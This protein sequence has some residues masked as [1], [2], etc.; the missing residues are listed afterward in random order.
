MHVPAS[1]QR[2]EQ[3]VL[4]T[5]SI[6]GLRAQILATQACDA[7]IISRFVD[8]SGKRMLDLVSFRNCLR[9][10]HFLRA[11]DYAEEEIYS[12]L[13]HASVYMMDASA[14]FGAR[15]TPIEWSNVMVALV[16][17]AHSYVLDETCPLSK[18]HRYLCRDYCSLHV[19]DAAV[20][21]LMATR[22]YVLRVDSKILE[23]RYAVF[24]RTAV[25]A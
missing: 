18:W 17:I 19:L 12:V 2:D 1:H 14:K 25:G 6:T 22:R 9:V 11:C 24:C 15:M 13:V 5:A 23:Y 10:M 8:F 7:N 3:S 4:R 16:F 21:R 20:L